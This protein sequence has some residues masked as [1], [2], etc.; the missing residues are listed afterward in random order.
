[1]ELGIAE[2]REA[3][4]A[5]HIAAMERRY[6]QAGPLRRATQAEVARIEPAGNFPHVPHWNKSSVHKILKLSKQ[7]DT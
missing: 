2:A 1:M 7:G 4:A 5:D 6:P 3:D